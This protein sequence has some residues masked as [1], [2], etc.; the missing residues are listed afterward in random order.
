M[1]KCNGLLPDHPFEQG[2]EFS[3]HARDASEETKDTQVSDD[4]EEEK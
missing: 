1:I 3:R 4:F 2:I